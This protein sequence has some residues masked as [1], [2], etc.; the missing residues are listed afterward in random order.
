MRERGDTGPEH[1]AALPHR[2]P[3]DKL[4][5][6]FSSILHHRIGT[7]ATIPG[8]CKLLIRVLVPFALQFPIRHRQRVTAENVFGID[9]I[10][11]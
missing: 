1:I 9:G 8:F 11:R 10:E 7:G 4:L 2:V 3:I 6:Q 5:R